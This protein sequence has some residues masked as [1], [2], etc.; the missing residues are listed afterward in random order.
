MKVGDLVRF[1]SSGA[2]GT[3]VNVYAPENPGG[4]VDLLVTDVTDGTLDSA[5]CSNGVTSMS[6]AMLW[7]T[8]EVVNESR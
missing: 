6:N 1:K 3:I 2:I 4:F 5:A 7:S 8:A